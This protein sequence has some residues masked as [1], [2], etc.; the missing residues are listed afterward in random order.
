MA[1]ESTGLLVRLFGAPETSGTPGSPSF[2]SRGYALLTLLTLAPGY[3]LSKAVAA[4]RIWDSKSS[5]ANHA[6][7]RQL[8]RRMALANPNISGLLYYD[9]RSIWLS[10]AAKLVDL[11][12][13][14]RM[15]HCSNI[16]AFEQV[17]EL[18]RGDLLQGLD[19]SGSPL[20]NYL[21]TTRVD[22]EER[23]FQLMNDTLKE[24]TRYGLR[25][26]SGLRRIEQLA[27]NVIPN[28][29]ATQCALGK[30]FA[31]VGCNDDAIRILNS[32]EQGEKNEVGADAASE[33]RTYISKNRRHVTNCIS[34]NAAEAGKRLGKVPR[35]ALL[36]P[37]V[38]SGVLLSKSLAH[39][40]IEDLANEMSR[41]NRYATLAAHSS[42]QA[43]HASGVLLEKATLNADFTISTCFQPSEGLGAI[44]VRLV[45]THS[46]TI[47]WADR[48]E[49]PQGHLFSIGRSLILRAAIE[50]S[51]AIEAISLARV[52]DN[53]CDSSYLSF[54]AGQQALRGCDLKSVRRARRSFL[55]CLRNDGTHAE[56]TSGLSF[57]LYLEWLLLGGTDP[58]LLA[59]ARD[60]SRPFQLAPRS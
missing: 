52:S 3:R 11:A 9:A 35:V 40:F 25:D 57:S 4:D 8:L 58:R 42:F 47:A 51:T 60:L 30:A 16:S 49:L 55:T 24:A 44:S 17:C 34:P 22:L 50:I 28:R 33:L 7:M 31:T 2:P 20:D 14:I 39:A 46:G 48:F 13:F 26:V 43:S 12:R 32:L 23:F 53:I 54:L 29:E 45:D 10:G 37:S 6:N 5:V 21:T 59:E 36:A 19:F 15:D 18:Y 41:D 38:L 56:A 27:L 1:D